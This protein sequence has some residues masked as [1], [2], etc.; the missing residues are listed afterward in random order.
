[1]DH[2]K[3]GIQGR[4]DRSVDFRL[5]HT[6]YHILAA[7]KSNRA[8]LNANLVRD[9]SLWSVNDED[10]EHFATTLG[11]PEIEWIAVMRGNVKYLAARINFDQDEIPWIYAYNAISVKYPNE[12]IKHAHR[13]LAAEGRLRSKDIIDASFICD[14]KIIRSTENSYKNGF[15]TFHLEGHW[16]DDAVMDPPYTEKDWQEVLIKNQ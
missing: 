6:A 1:V 5:T 3:L 7:R 14:K 9:A 13:S 12:T 15:V 16:S 4:G 2:Q 11:S 8:L 10:H